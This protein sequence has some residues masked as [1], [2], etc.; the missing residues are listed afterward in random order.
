MVADYA[1]SVSDDWYLALCEAD[2][3][4]AVALK[5]RRGTWAPAEQ[6]RTPIEVAHAL[7]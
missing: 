5:P 7:T 6:P 3:A 4:Y 1:Y 2:L